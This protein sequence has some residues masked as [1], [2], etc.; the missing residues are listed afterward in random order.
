MLPLP[1]NK[2]HIAPF[3]LLPGKWLGRFPFIRKIEGEC[4]AAKDH[5][6]V[7]IQFAEIESPDG[8]QRHKDKNNLR[9]RTNNAIH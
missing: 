1:P 6:I 5:K 9:R 3:S 4:C 2:F 8:G 7:L